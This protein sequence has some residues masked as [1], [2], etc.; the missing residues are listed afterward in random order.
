MKPSGPIPPYF[1][2][3]EDGQLLIGGSPAEELV[4]EAGG[5][6][7]FVYDNNIVGAQIASLRAAMPDGLALYYSVTANPYEPLLNFIGRYV[8]GFRI[9]SKGELERLKRAELAGI[10]M[11]FAGPGKSGDVCAMNVQ[12]PRKSTNPSI[13]GNTARTIGRSA[14]R[15]AMRRA[16]R[17]ARR[18]AS[19]ASSSSA[20]P[21][22]AA[23]LSG[24]RIG[25]TRADAGE[26]ASRAAE[27]VSEAEIIP[28][29]RRYPPAT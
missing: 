10:P 26:R 24:G 23:P 3:N 2:A 21:D 15:W 19:S 20:G 17:F 27:A 25:D 7:L 12:R 13:G 6:P 14:S 28:S 8:E 16:S 1:S 11:T 22:D 18:A 4:A 5:T 9:V 29:L